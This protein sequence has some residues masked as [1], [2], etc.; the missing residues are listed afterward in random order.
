[1]LICVL[2][3]VAPL[4]VRVLLSRSFVFSALAAHANLTINIQLRFYSA[5]KAAAT[6]LKMTRESSQAM[7]AE[8]SAETTAA[9]QRRAD[10]KSSEFSCNNRS[11]GVFF[12]FRLFQF[13]TT[14]AVRG[15]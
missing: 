8:L 2:F 13:I 3:Y 11:C 15:D 14:V 10:E 9:A 7:A 4:V 5:L 6:E 1:M 12:L